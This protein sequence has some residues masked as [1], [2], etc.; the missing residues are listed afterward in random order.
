MAAH[1]I[2]ERTL[3]HPA[4]SAEFCPRIGD[5]SNGGCLLAVGTYLL[6][7]QASQAKSGC[8]HIFEVRNDSNS[9]NSAREDEVATY[10]YALSDLTEYPT[11]AVFDIKW[12]PDRYQ[13]G[14]GSVMA[15]AGADGKATILVVEGEA[16]ARN[17]YSVRHLC[18]SSVGERTMALS[19][20]WGHAGCGDLDTLAVSTSDGE[21]CLLKVRE[22]R[23]EEEQRWR[24]HD[25]ETWIVAKDR[26]QPAVLFSGADDCKMKVWDTRQG[27][28]FPVF[29]DKRTHTMG[30]CCLQS[31][32]TREHILCSGSYDEKVR[33]WDT[34][35]LRAPLTTA[36]HETGGGVWRLKW[37]PENPE[38]L[39]AACMH[40]GFSVLQVESS[41]AS[42]ETVATY[43][44]QSSLAYG[45][46][47][48]P[49]GCVAGS[50]GDNIVATCSFYD[51]LLH[52]WV[53]SL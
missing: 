23:A 6:A 24:A 3:S 1:V 35:N 50:G 28:D 30:V 39:L 42:M 14:G 36:T 12:R 22:G 21:L 48:M 8:V 46:D 4:C 20:D 44:A 53:P 29:V 9:G 32:P 43:T 38:L 10:P 41:M 26:F 31:H 13:A 45:A 17:G 52:V 34:R 18:E 5:G 51:K 16:E 49:G 33:L 7:D 47:W 11:T 2:A 27:C 37:H 15:V 19:L 25:M 40:A